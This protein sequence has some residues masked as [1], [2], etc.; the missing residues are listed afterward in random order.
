MSSR[1]Q[2]P[3]HLPR[4]QW[5][6]A[7]SIVHQ[8]KSCPQLCT[9][10]EDKAEASPRLPVVPPAASH[11]LPPLPTQSLCPNAFLEHQPAGKTLGSWDPLQDA[12]CELNLT[13]KSLA[14]LSLVS[15]CNQI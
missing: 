3:R 15:S 8:H 7:H 14:T 2:N 11:L 6:A 4:T 9:A 12:G 5:G 1:P 10:A 13:G